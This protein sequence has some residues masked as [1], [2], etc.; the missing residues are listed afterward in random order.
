MPDTKN[1]KVVSVERIENEHL[2]EMYQTRKDMRKTVLARAP[3][4][5]KLSAVT[6]WQLVLTASMADLS[7]DVNE[8]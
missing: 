7:A 4:V 2:W 3:S 1:L 8:F 6:R 5:R